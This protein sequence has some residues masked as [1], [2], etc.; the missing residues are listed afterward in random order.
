MEPP[1]LIADRAYILL[2]LAKDLWR[3]P[4]LINPLHPRLA[5]LRVPPCIHELL[6]DTSRLWV[7]VGEQ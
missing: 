3:I 7:C 2:V 4:N 1:E 6:L 5:Q